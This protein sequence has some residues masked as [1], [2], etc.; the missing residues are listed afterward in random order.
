MCL[1][2][3]LVWV[4]FVGLLIQPF[5]VI[6]FFFFLRFVNFDDLGWFVKTMFRVT[7]EELGETYADMTK[8]FHYFV[9]FL[10]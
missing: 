2:D 3:D 1:F 10:R 7:N 4:Y 5:C 6:S 9:D 8:P